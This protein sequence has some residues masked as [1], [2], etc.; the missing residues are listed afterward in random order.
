MIAGQFFDRFGKIVSGPE[1]GDGQPAEGDA[2]PR[3]KWLG[4]FKK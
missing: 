1:E 3:R 4:L 2:K